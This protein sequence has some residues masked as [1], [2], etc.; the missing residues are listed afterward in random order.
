MLSTSGAAVCVHASLPQESAVVTALW[1]TDLVFVAMCS[2]RPVGWTPG[3]YHGC[4]LL[5]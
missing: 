3:L 1:N 5:A 2:G 4:W